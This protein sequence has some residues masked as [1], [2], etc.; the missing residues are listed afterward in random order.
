MNTDLSGASVNQLEEEPLGASE[1]PF[2]VPMPSVTAV[3][4][5]KLSSPLTPVV[6]DDRALLRLLTTLLERS[7]Q[8]AGDVARRLGLTDN[9]ILQYT[10]GRR[11][12]PSLQWFLRFAEMCGAKVYIE[13]PQREIR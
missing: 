3:P 11:T 4:V 10:K 12:R 1:S 2:L 6:C 5:V 9:S 7:G 8:S 13:L